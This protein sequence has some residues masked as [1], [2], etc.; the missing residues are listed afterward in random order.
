MISEGIPSPSFLP[1]SLFGR[2]YVFCVALLV[3]SA[4]LSLQAAPSWEPVGLSGGGGLF[5]PAISP[6]DPNLMMINCDM[7]AAYISED[8][9][10][11]WRMIPQAQ[12]RS[13]TRCRPAFHPSNRDVIYASSGGGLRVS[14]DRGQTF[15]PIGNLKDSLDGE[16]SIN[17]E[18][19]SVLIAGTGNER[20]SIS[21]DGG[22]SW[23]ACSGP[24]GRVIGFHFD[25]TRKAQVIFAATSIGIWR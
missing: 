24:K 19:P 4:A 17:P 6:A 14:H 2:L 22:Q 25:R 16:I 13:D 3:S 23:T 8:G 1:R 9:G 21:K 18:N 10:H 15:S 5:T 7:S 20:C 11:N 12:L